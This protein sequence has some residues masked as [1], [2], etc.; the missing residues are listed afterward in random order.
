MAC[1]DDIGRST[2]LGIGDGNREA[3]QGT[4]PLQG[5]VTSI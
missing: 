5:S 1:D 2:E 4:A 3:K